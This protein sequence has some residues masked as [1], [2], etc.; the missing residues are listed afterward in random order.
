MFGFLKRLFAGPKKQF[1]YAPVIGGGRTVR[2]FRIGDYTARLITDI[3]SLGS[4]EYTHILAVFDAAGDPVYFVASEVNS[5]VAQLGGGTHFLG[6]FDGS[7]HV[8]L[9]NSDQWSDLETFAAEA[10]KIAKKQ[11]GIEE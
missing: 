2:E 6:V 7:G 1:G 10:V 8:S 3:K 9:D 4:V 11:L 5:M